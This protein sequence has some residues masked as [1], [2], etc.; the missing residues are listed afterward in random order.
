MRSELGV[1]VNKLDKSVRDQLVAKLLLYGQTSI[2][3]GHR[4]GI[5]AKWGRDGIGT[6]GTEVGDKRTG[7]VCA[8]LLTFDYVGIL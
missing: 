1:S 3:V 7:S 8:A 6:V 5:A 2:A 4:C